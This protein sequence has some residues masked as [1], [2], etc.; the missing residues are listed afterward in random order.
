MQILILLIAMGQV[1]AAGEHSGSAWPS[2]Q[3]QP[4]AAPAEIAPNQ[5]EAALLMTFTASW[6]GPCHRM[7]PFLDTIKAEGTPVQQVNYDSDRALADFYRVTALPTTI[8]LRHGVEVG[9]RIGV[10]SIDELRAM[11]RA[12]AAEPYGPKPVEENSKRP[13]VTSGRSLRHFRILPRRRSGW[14]VK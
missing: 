6:C 10:L 2:F 4:Q 1:Q 14:P 7:T 11:V 9:R 12:P 13:K 8:V 3:E 5:D